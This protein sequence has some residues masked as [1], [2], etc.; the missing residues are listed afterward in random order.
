MIGMSHSSQQRAKKTPLISARA[1]LFFVGMVEGCC[2]PVFLR[3]AKG[4]DVLDS[5]SNNHG[6]GFR[7]RSPSEMS[8]SKIPCQL[9]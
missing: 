5:L 9:P 4:L 2:P 3:D 1:S 6:S 7:G 8:C